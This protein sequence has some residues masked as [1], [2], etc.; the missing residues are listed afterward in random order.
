MKISKPCEWPCSWPF[1][2][3][4]SHSAPANKKSS[5]VFFSV[6]MIDSGR[7]RRVKWL[8]FIQSPVA[9]VKSALKHYAMIFRSFFSRTSFLLWSQLMCNNLWLYCSCLI[10]CA[11]IH[12]QNAPC[13][14]E[15]RKIGSVVVS[16]WSEADVHW[17]RS[18]ALSVK[19]IEKA[20]QELGEDDA[21][22]EECLCQFR[23]WIASH[24]FIKSCRQGERLRELLRPS[25]SK[26]F[27]LFQMTAF[28]CS[29][30]E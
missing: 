21:K 28:S 6:G 20:R 19:F 12:F 15:K 25:T 30:S 4:S 26:T 10:P 5:L 18:M 16:I 11:V 14:D 9:R 8:T 3:A 17:V 24:S 7:K 22:R 2:L 1:M 23:E 29:S 13:A 27:S